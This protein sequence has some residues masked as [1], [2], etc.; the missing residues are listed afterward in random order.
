MQLDAFCP[1]RP[2]V[3]WALD[4]QYG[5]TAAGRALK[6]LNIIDELTRECLAMVVLVDGGWVLHRL[7]FGRVGEHL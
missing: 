2:D 1:V 6:L 3:V 5:Q 4:L 7:S